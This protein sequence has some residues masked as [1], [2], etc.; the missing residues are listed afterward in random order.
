MSSTAR[1]GD[2][3]SGPGANHTERGT[4]QRSVFRELRSRTRNGDDEERLL[5]R[6]RNG[7]WN[8]VPDAGGTSTTHLEERG[9]SSARQP[10]ADRPSRQHTG[11]CFGSSPSAHP[12]SSRRP[13]FNRPSSR[14]RLHGGGRDARVLGRPPA[15]ARTSSW[16]R[17][18]ASHRWR[19]GRR[20]RR[21]A[22]GK[23]EPRRQHAQE[24]GVPARTKLQSAAGGAAAAGG[25][26]RVNGLC[27]GF[28]W[29]WHRAT[30]HQACTWAM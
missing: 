28:S 10:A 8:V 9:A 29:A 13:P 11:Y 27:G 7:A 21:A 3:P 26:R 17:R 5:E 4:T 14:R 15:A 12:D 6:V 2:R 23:A 20:K 1:L 19:S 30:A 18:R 25:G 24:G 16:W 22:R